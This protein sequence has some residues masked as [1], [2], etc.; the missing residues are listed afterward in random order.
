MPDHHILI[1]DILKYIFN[2]FHHE[3]T[4]LNLLWFFVCVRLV[5][6]YVNILVV[7]YI[8]QINHRSF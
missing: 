5:L 8:N 3:K 6:S 7:I 2:M 4:I 1:E